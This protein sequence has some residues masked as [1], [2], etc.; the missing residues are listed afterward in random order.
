MHCQEQCST[1]CV[2]AAVAARSRRFR[3]VTSRVMTELLT[4]SAALIELIRNSDPAGQCDFLAYAAPEIQELARQIE[5]TE[6]CMKCTG[7]ICG[8]LD[9]SDVPE[10]CRGYSSGCR[11]MN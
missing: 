10:W 6:E 11:S 3:D 8:S 1:G 5:L 2:I 7:E 4:A 9:E